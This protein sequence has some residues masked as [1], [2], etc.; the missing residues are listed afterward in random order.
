[1]L[2]IAPASAAERRPDPTPEQ[3]ALL[4]ELE[5][6]AGRFVAAGRAYDRSVR[7][8]L[9]RELLRRR[10]GRARYFDAALGEETAALAESRVDAIARL[11]RC[12]GR[13]PE[14][15][16]Y[17]PDTMFRLGELYFETSSEAFD[18]AYAAAEGASGGADVPLEPDFGRTLDLYRRIVERF[19]GYRNVD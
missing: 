8:I 16:E 7:A 4:R 17:T 11:E 3:V 5:V 14:D 19:P 6:E 2:R 12:L 18:E 10:G 1:F 15:P 13:Y 9:D